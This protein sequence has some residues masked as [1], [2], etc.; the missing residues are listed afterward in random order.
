MKTINGGDLGLRLERFP[1]VV[2]AFRMPFGCHALEIDEDTQGSFFSERHLLIDDDL[3]RV[4]WN[5]A[6]GVL[7]VISVKSTGVVVKMTYMVDS[8]VLAVAILILG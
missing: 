2:D 4:L 6:C 3:P 5:T 7:F 8:L 1:W